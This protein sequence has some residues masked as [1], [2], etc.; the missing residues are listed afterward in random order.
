MLIVYYIKPR[1]RAHARSAMD[2]YEKTLTLFQ[3]NKAITTRDARVY[4]AVA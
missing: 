4:N 2:F 1:P 3:H